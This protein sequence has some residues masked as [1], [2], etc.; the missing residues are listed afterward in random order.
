MPGANHLQALNEHLRVTASNLREALRAAG[1]AVTAVEH[2]FNRPKG[3][4][5]PKGVSYGG[6]VAEPLLS[7]ATLMRMFQKDN[8]A[9][10]FRHVARVCLLKAI[11]PH[12]QR[13]AVTRLLQQ[14]LA[15]HGSPK[16]TSSGAM[17]G[18]HGPF[19]FGSM[20]LPE[21]RFSS[22]NPTF[23]IVMPV[24][25]KEMP[26]ARVLERAGLSHLLQPAEEALVAPRTTAA[27]RGALGAN[28]PGVVRGKAPAAVRSPAGGRSRAGAPSRARRG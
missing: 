12:S 7:H 8:S 26:V 11:V 4:F 25:L 20:T 15:K 22:A 24:E 19:A 28:K 1:C 17:L 3:S 2:E 21:P 16:H 13:E 27:R 23:S 6:Y 14:A 9:P 10:S 5:V 18:F